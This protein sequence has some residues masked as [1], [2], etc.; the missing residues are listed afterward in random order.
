MGWG[1]PFSKKGWGTQLAKIGAVVAGSAL[2]GPLGGAAAGAAVGGMGGGG[3]GGAAKG[4]IMG[5]IG[6]LLAGGL[7]SAA[8]TPMSGGMQGATQ[9]S[10]LSGLFTGGGSNLGSIFSGAGTASFGGGLFGGGSSAG[11]PATSSLGSLFGGASGG[12]GG[13]SSLTSMFGS[14]AGSPMTGGMQGATQGSGVLGSLTGGGG[15]LGSLFGGGGGSMFGGGNMGSLLNAGTSI[16]SGL[17]QNNA[18]NDIEKQKLEAERQRM[19]QIQPYNVSG[20]AANQSLAAKLASGELGGKFNA[21]DL[22]GDPVYQS[23]LT[24]GQTAL[25]RKA[26]ASGN[27]FS[28]AA[29]KEAT[30]YSQDL[31]AQKQNEAYNRWLGQQQ[32]TYNQ[33]AQQSSQGL[34]AATGVG[35]IYS[36]M[37]DVTSG[38]TGAQSNNLNATLASL[39]SG[40]N[41]QSQPKFDAYGNLIYG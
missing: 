18:I 41:N 10:G 31:A 21:L 13:L 33:L 40:M 26:A 9:G 5:G 19:A 6:G 4:G 23:E 39:L 11:A 16:F 7:G 14:S 35:N 34:N 30:K 28:G 37:G 32:N 25:D 3:L 38:A 27:V 36:G 1:K 24:Q 2:G 29:L 17:Q 8:G 20:Q 12:S 15:G 22:S